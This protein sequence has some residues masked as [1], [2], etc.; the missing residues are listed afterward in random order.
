[1]LAPWY[2]L[3]VSDRGRSGGDAFTQQL[4]GWDALS[5]AAIVCLIVAIGVCALIAVR[6]VHDVSGLGAEGRRAARARIDGGLIAGGGLVCVVTLLWTAVA[7]PAMA[8]GSPAAITHTTARSGVLLALVLAAALT[9][10]GVQIL[11]AAGRDLRDRR[12]G[13][14][15]TRRRPGQP[16]PG[17]ST[18]ENSALSA[19]T[20]RIPSRISQRRRVM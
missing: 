2:S 9:A 6:S 10:I 3:R 19:P 15:M 12:P 4:S 16:A 17:R 11:A 5:A 20:I 14:S 13:R 1:M 8:A 7:P 18:N